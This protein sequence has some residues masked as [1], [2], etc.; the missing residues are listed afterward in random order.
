MILKNNAG[1]TYPG[2]GGGS[3]ATMRGH[4]PVEVLV[5][6]DIERIATSLGVDIVPRTVDDRLRPGEAEKGAFEGVKTAQPA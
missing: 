1:A 2:M 3:D 4:I 5:R 6:F